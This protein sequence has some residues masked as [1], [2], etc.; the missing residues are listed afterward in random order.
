[1]REELN[2]EGKRVKI[3]YQWIARDVCGNEA[4]HTQTISITPKKVVPPAAND[5]AYL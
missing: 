4:V 2:E 5:S 1:M 3:I